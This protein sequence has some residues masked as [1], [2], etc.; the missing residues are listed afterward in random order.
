MHD[1]GEAEGEGE[2]G[3]EGLAAA[4]GVHA[5]GEAGVFVEHV[6]IEA[7]GAALVGALAAAFEAVAAAAH[8]DQTGA[9][10]DEG[11]VEEGGEHEALK[12]EAERVFSGDGVGDLAGEGVGFLK[13]GELGLEFGEAGE[14]GGEA[15]EIG[16]V[17]GALGDRGLVGGL[18]LAGGGG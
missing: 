18:G 14:R 11:V 17:A 6:E 13:G 15:G 10:G 2:R 3:E 5:A 7:G 12:R 1:V 8:L 16:G 9:G 4:E